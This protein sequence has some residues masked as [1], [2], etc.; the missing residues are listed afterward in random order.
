[1]F[2]VTLLLPDLSSALVPW[3]KSCSD[4]DLATWLLTTCGI[5]HRHRRNLVT[6]CPV[7]HHPGYSP[8]L[9]P[10]PDSHVND[11]RYGISDASLSKWHDQ[12]KTSMLDSVP[13]TDMLLGIYH[14]RYNLVT[15][16]PSLPCPSHPLRSLVNFRFARQLSC[17]CRGCFHGCHPCSSIVRSKLWLDQYP[18]GTVP[19]RLTQLPAPIKQSQLVDTF[20]RIY[21]HQF[22]YTTNH[23]STSSLPNQVASRTFHV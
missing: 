17:Q 3:F 16:L 15:C 19:A 8:D 18:Y 14:C 6:C 7:L 9:Q 23:D 5:I 11:L 21:P 12:I 10:T 1:M 2:V 13:F 20:R 22:T 4:C